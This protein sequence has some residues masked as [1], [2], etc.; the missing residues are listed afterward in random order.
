VLDQGLLKR[1][2]RDHRLEWMLRAG[3]LQVLL[4]GMAANNVRFT[5]IAKLREL[6]R[7]AG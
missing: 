5:D 1:H 6:P 7:L 3:G 2:Y 4:D